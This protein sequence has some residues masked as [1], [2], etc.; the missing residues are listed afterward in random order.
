M[1]PYLI[2]LSSDALA[3]YSSSIFE[4]AGLSSSIGLKVVAALQIPVL[5]LAL[6]LMDRSG[7]RPLLLVSATG[8]F[9]SY[10]LLGLSFLFKEISYLKEFSPIMSLVGLLGGYTSSSLGMSGIPWIIMSEIFPVNVKA[11][12]GTLVTL[13]H[14][15]CAWIVTYSFNFMMEWSS[16][17]TIFIFSGVAALTVIFIAR[18]V[19]ETKGKSLEEIQALMTPFL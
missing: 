15:S 17:G 5:V 9:L 6:L 19:P 1:E 2:N 14:W 8:M 13:V 10:I 7:R 3:Y 4:E 16:T 12:A 11:S 18:F